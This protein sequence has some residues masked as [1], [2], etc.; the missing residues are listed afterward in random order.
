M[1]VCSSQQPVLSTRRHPAHPVISDTD[2]RYWYQILRRITLYRTNQT[3][4]VRGTYRGRMVFC[5]VFC[6]VAVSLLDAR[7]RFTHRF[8][9][10]PSPPI[11]F[12]IFARLFYRNGL[13][14]QTPVCT[15]RVSRQTLPSL[16]PGTRYLWT[17]PYPQIQ[18]VRYN[19]NTHKSSHVR[20]TWY[21]MHEWN[22]KSRSTHPRLILLRG[23]IVIRTHRIHKNLYIT[24]FLLI[25]FG[26][27]YYVPP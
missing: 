10:F 5:L 20:T 2:I 12:I 21:R 15:C 23:G 17:P 22:T 27:Y 16:L 26:P 24:L 18:G 14:N 9:Y 6:H 3:S 1:R 19:I 4:C 13:K 8:N 11:P 25:I 7:V